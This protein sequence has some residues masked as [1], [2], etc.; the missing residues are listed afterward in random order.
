M[1]HEIIEKMPEKSENN[2]AQNLYEK[3]FTELFEKLKKVITNLEAHEDN[4]KEKR[5]F[6]LTL[7]KNCKDQTPFQ[8]GIHKKLDRMVDIFLSHFDLETVVTDQKEFE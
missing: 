6:A 7:V 1:F 3:G 8:L 2:A 5:N 4:V